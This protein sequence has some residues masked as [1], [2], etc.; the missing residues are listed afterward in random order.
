MINYTIPEQSIFRAYDIRGVVDKTLT[1]EVLYAIGLGIGSE[2][3][4]RGQHKVVV[5]YDGRLSGPSFAKAMADGLMAS[6]CD[7]IMIGQVTSPMLYYATCVLDT[8]S[9]VMITGSHNPPDYNGIKTVIAG[10]TIYGDDLQKI[11][12]RIADKK[13][14]QG[15]GAIT[16]VDILA[17]YI[18]RIVSGISLKRKLKV[19][20]D[21]GNGVGGKVAPTLFEKLGCE[22][23]P[24]FCEVDGTFPN[25]HPDPSVIE[26]L[27][28]I[29]AKIKTEKADVG[30]AF[31]GDADRVGLVTNLGEVIMPDRTLIFLARDALKR[32]PGA[33]I[34]F[35]VKCSRHVAEEITKH[36]GKPE[37]IQTG[38]A[39]LKAKV[40]AVNAPVAGELSGHIFYTE[41]WYGFDDGIYDAARILEL[42]SQDS[43]TCSEI[44]ATVPDSINTPELK[45]EMADDKKFKFMEDFM[46]QAKFPDGKIITIDGLRVDFKDGFGLMRPSNTTP[47]IIFRFEGDTKEALV[48]IQNTFREKLL[49]FDKNLV[50]PF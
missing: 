31:D 13:I 25:H 10:N 47:I 49:A 4:D 21:C 50:L 30:L 44:F 1:P 39:I 45:M 17:Q 28:D 29:I 15:K 46:A 12:Q 34:P 37:M 32:H 41:R 6:G 9:G 11:Y 7:V 38:H 3:Q 19:V 36:G 42:L 35:D 22:V 27:K 48:R 26:N 8:K 24:L 2:A 33:I 16:E 14:R 23:I 40:K 18:E 5:G 43:R 20:I